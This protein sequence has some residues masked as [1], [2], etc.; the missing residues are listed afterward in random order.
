[1]WGIKEELHIFFLIEKV[2][3][4]YACNLDHELFIVSQG[5]S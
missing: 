5:Q 3:L 1:M 4:V 2:I